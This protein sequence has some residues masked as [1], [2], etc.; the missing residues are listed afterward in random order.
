MAESSFRRA[1]QEAVEL[2]NRIEATKFC[3]WLTPNDR[4]FEVEG[5]LAFQICCG[6]AGTGGPSWRLPAAPRLVRVLIQQR[7]NPWEVQLGL[8]ERA[9]FTKAHQAQGLT[10]LLISAP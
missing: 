9:P 10:K 4:V 3:K 1:A 2:A 8:D 5:P 6:K 7:Q